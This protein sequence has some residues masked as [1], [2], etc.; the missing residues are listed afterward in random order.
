MGRR[1]AIYQ[2]IILGAQEIQVSAIIREIFR[3]LGRRYEHSRSDRDQ[4]ITVNWP[5]TQLGKYSHT[6]NICI[7]NEN[8]HTSI[9]QVC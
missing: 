7:V 1:A 6:S 8:T 2:A 4:Y 9:M 5:Q 3:A